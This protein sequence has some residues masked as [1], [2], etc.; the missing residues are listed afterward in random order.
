MMLIAFTASATH[1]IATDAFAILILKEKERSLGNSMQS[2]GNFLGTLTGSGVLLVIYHYWGWKYLLFSLAAFV[3]VALIP[4]SFYPVREKKK[5]DKS[6][7]NVSYLEFVWFFRQKKILG[8]L[9]LLF[10]FY[11]GLIGILTMIKPYL[12]DLGYNVKEIGFIS[13]IFGTACG[14]IMTIPA[15]LLIRKVGLTRSVWIFPTLSFLAASYFFI[16]TFTNH[17]LYLIYIGVALLWSAYAMSSVFIYTLS[18]KVVRKGR[19]GTDFTIQIVITHFSS[20]IIAVMS[21]KIAD[22]IN[23]RGLYLIEII[24]GVLIFILIPFIFK[25]NFYQQ[26][27]DS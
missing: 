13:G 1:D 26:Y 25:N 9:I 15:G 2:A 16:L 21:G 6:R 14:A 7:K 11:S 23:Y 12:V 27:G 10:L 22:A 19:E 17:Q 18:M 3:V 4:V 20:L 24:I 5:L 8:H